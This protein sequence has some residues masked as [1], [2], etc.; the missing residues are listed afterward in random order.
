MNDNETMSRA[1]IMRAIEEGDRH[2]GVLAEATDDKFKIIMETYDVLNK[3]ID[4]VDRKLEDF[5]GEVNMKFDLL[6]DGQDQLFTG[7]KQLL[8]GQKQLFDGQDQLFAGQKTL[9]EDNQRFFE[10]LRAMRRE[11]EAKF[12]EVFERFDRLER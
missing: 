8:D 5:R 7:Q 9:F 3:K 1:E 11:S 4:G 10:E 12:K 6:F 2:A